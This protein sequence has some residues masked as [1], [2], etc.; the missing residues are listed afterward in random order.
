MKDSDHDSR[1]SRKDRG[2]ATLCNHIRPY[3]TCRILCGTSACLQRHVHRHSISAPY[4]TPPNEGA[5]ATGRLNLR[6]IFDRLMVD[7]T[8][9]T[10]YMISEQQRSLA[11]NKVRSAR[12]CQAVQKSLCQVSSL[13][14]PLHPPDKFQAC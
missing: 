4:A 5:T 6:H 10:R 2:Y 7:Q 9:K 13:F 12:S 14:L 11:R 1:D 3:R 8:T